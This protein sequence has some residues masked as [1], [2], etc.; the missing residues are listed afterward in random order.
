MVTRPQRSWRW[1]RAAQLSAMPAERARRL[2][3]AAKQAAA[4]RLFDMVD[5]LLAAAESQELS[6]FDRV[7]ADLLRDERDDAAAGDSGR[8][9]QLCA[10]AGQAAAAGEDGLALELAYA[11][12]HRRFSAHVNARAVSAV[13]SLAVA[14]AHE[15][16]NPR[17]LAVLALAAPIRHGRRVVARLADAAEEAIDDANSLRALSVAAYAVGDYARG[18]ELLDRAEA[19]L[20]RLGLHG[21]LAPLLCAGADIR[22][23]L[24]QWDRAAA[25]LAEVGT[26]G[27]YLGQRPDVL[28]TAAKAAALRGGTSVALELVAQAEHCPAARRGSSVLARAQIARGIAR[29]SSG[30]H[31]DAYTALSRVFDPRD[32]SHHFREQ[33]SAVMYTAEAAVRCG[34][35]DGARAIVDRME[36][37]A[38]ES[39]SPLLLTQLRYARAVL[40]SDDTAEQLFLGCLAS[41]LASWPWPRARVQLAYG[42]WLRRQRRVRQSR[43]PLQAALS[44]LTGLGAVTWARDALDEL[45]A[46]AGRRDENRGPESPGFPLSAQELKIARLAARGLSNSEIGDQLGLSPRTVGSHLYRMFPKLDISA[47]AQLAA[48]LA[49]HQLT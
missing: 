7:R 47:R 24:G 10:T 9:L 29:I 13:T 49:E 39:G 2:L 21:G 37:I 16:E 14:V 26:L 42:R 44:A 11:A 8:V 36:V 15:R 38:H 27:P 17:A 22:L 34:Q 35:D 46:A 41:D 20:R 12:S 3:L 19:A 1:K 43:G 31:L 23:D 40:A 18:C 30:K 25:A 48:R 6:G 5:R 28:S 33:F 45:E 32:P 4:M